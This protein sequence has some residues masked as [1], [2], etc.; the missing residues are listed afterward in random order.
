MYRLR[1][2]SNSGFQ[3]GKDQRAKFFCI[4]FMKQ[5]FEMGERG[6]VLVN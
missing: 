3:K 1:I 6:E 5:G 4:E 2:L